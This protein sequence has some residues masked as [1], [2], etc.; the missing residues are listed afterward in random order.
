ML[1]SLHTSPQNSPSEENKNKTVIA[2]AG[3]LTGHNGCVIQEV[4]EPQLRQASRHDTGMGHGVWELR[5]GGEQ[6]AGAE[7]EVDRAAGAE[8]SQWACPRP[9]ELA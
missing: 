7:L 3:V 1:H 8:P 5:E 6:G 4:E 9:C 2:G